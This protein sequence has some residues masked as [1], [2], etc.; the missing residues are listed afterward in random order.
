[1]NK[2]DI[3]DFDETV[4]NNI[5][6]QY[7]DFAAELHI[8]DIRFVPMSAL[9]GDN[10]VTRSE[11]TPWYSGETLM[12]TLDSVQIT[13]DV[14]LGAFRLPVQ[15]VN[16]PN[17]DFRG[18]CGTVAS[19]QIRQGDT[20]TALPSGKQADVKSVLTPSGEENTGFVGQAITVTLDREIDISRGDMIVR[21]DETLPNMSQ[22]FD[23][24]I[25]WMNDTPLVPGKEYAFKLGGKTVFGRIEKILHRV[26][27]NS[28]EHLAAE[29]LSLNEIGL[30]RVVVNAPVVFDAYRICRGTGSLIIIDRL[31]NATAGA[32]MIAATAEADIEL[33]RAHIEA[34]LLGMSEQDL[35]D[36]VTRHYPHWG[37]KPLS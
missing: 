5:R 23:A 35:H 34:V 9:R 13:H 25:V 8:S 7:L 18:F 28:L 14:T 1:V 21:A 15:F 29:Q 3:V 16:R 10:V 32:G 37:V 33:Q 11:K 22:A 36:F 27:V 20:I 6:Q 2:M 31:S 26:E 12:E 24:H 17:L 4:F 19:G 30:C